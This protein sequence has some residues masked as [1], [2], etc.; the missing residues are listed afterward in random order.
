MPTTRLEFHPLT[1]VEE[2]DGVT[3]GRVDGTSYAQLPA[4]GVALLKRLADGMS[5]SEAAAWYS[6]SF[7]EAVDIDDFVDA[8]RDL[9]FVRTD[10]ED[11]AQAPA[12]RFQALGRAAFS[13]PAW[14]AYSLLLVAAAVAM[15]VRPELRPHAANVF[16]LPSL[17]AVQFA[18]ALC[19]SPAILW[20]E[21]FHWLA[22]RRLGLSSRLRIGRRYYYLVV[23]TELDALL[24]VP[25]RRRYLP[26]L[27]GLFA[28]LFLFAGLV[29]V[30]AA[31]LPAWPGGL[32]LAIAYTV[33]LRMAWQF[34]IFL[35]TDLY[36]VLT[37]ALGCTNLHEVSRAYLR[38][39]FRRLPWVRPSDW[40]TD[41]WTPRDRRMAPTFAL[42]MVGG[43]LA[44]IAT[45]VLWTGPLIVEFLTRVITAMSHGTSGGR[46]F[47]DSV[48]SLLFV[49]IELV[50]LPLLAG[51]AGRRRAAASTPA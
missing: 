15:A 34:Y 24:G 46:G 3:V 5:P 50:V 4:D 42:I 49:A 8:M 27:S 23:E 9:G 13:A 35:R 47:W 43:V 36:Y 25:P 6:V 7:G 45:V 16:F 19:Q 26:M 21:W 40:A 41:Q 32:A 33:L 20:H 38:H 1:Y 39:R 17:I 30:A 31:A 51:R 44:M 12:V 10:G 28:D 48:G 22:A 11:V 37:T 2:R 14:A 18:L 29:L